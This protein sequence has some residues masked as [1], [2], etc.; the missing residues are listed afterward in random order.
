MAQFKRKSDGAIVEAR[1]VNATPYNA[2][3]HATAKPTDKNTWSA[4]D[5]DINGIGLVPFGHMIVTDTD[6]II[7][8]PSDAAFKEQYEPVAEAEK[9]VAPPVANKL[10]TGDNK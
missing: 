3:K 9:S 2:T 7:T 8:A 5:E 6:G 4:V 1:P 10:L